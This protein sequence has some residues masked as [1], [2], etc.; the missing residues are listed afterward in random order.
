MKPPTNRPC[1]TTSAKPF[2]F[3]SL[4]PANKIPAFGNP[5]T[6]ATIPSPTPPFSAPVTSRIASIDLIRGAVMIIMAIDHVRVYSGL[7]AGGPTPGIFFTRWITHF[8]APAFIF[9]AGTSIFF[10]AR[11]HSDTSRFLVIRGLWLIFLELTVLRLAWTFNL[12]FAHYEMAGVLW[13]I[14]WCMI[15]M[16]IFVKLPLPVAGVFG[17]VIIAAHNLMDSHIGNILPT[18]N[19]HQFSGLWKILYFGFFAGPVQFG[20][21]GPN[22]VV[23][24]SII[25]WVG[26]MVA[27]HAFGK[28]LTFDAARRNRICFVIGLGAIALFL[29]LRGFNLY[30]DPR[31]WHAPQP[32]SFQP[33]AALSFLNCNKYPASLCFLLM[34]LGPVITLIPLL[35]NARGTLARMITTFGRV[36][37]FYYVLHVPLIHFLALIV[38]KIRL[39]YVSPWLFANHPM[40]SPEAPDG[41]IWSLPLLYLVWAI[42]IVILYPICRRFA[43]FKARSSAAW[44]KYI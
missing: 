26:V 14:G 37:F 35:E 28:I 5:A 16:A 33:P 25:P 8:C 44:L 36:P 30:G 29:I 3:L 41:Y 15:A 34:T 24:Y 27:G 13:V 21:D 32:G 19:S 43:E 23:L 1:R 9:L 20:A 4:K 39:G 11:K 22:L 10:Y 6:M 7:P 17:V 42:A 40:G 31:P 12:D 18:L 38:S 2:L